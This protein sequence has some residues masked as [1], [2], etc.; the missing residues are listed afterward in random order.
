M[1][2][3]PDAYLVI[4]ALIFILISLYTEFVGASY[5]FVIA[6][7]FLGI[8]R[9]LTPSEILAGLANEQIAI[10]IMLLLVGEIYRQT[11]VLNGLFD[12]L[13]NGVKSPGQFRRRMMWITGSFSAFLNNTP[14]V[15]LMMP[16]VHTWSKRN[17]VSVSKFLIPLSYA[18]ILGGCVTLVGT[19]TN[20]IVGG[21][22]LDQ[23]V[24]P[25]VEPLG[26]FEF[27]AVGIPM[28]FIGFIYLSLASNKLLPDRKAA[29]E[30]LHDQDRKYIVEVEVKPGCPLIGKVIK[31]TEF[32]NA[33][34]LD[35]V[36]IVRADQRS[37]PASPNIV[38]FE[39]D[40]LVFAGNVQQIAE[41]V[42]TNNGLVIP[43]VGMFA[44]KAETQVVEIAISHNSSFI[45]KAIKY[46]NFRKQYDATII[47]IHRN[48]EVLSGKIE[49]VIIQSGDAILLLAG[50]NFMILE[51]SQKDF[52]LISQVKE[53]RKL[54]FLKT[55]I[56]I[57]GTIG[58]I[59]LSS[60]G[61]IKLF[62]GI[63]TLLLLSL[64]FKIS[65]PKELPKSIDYDLALII[66]LSLSLGIAMTKTGVAEFI[67]QQ[68][69][70]LF[71]P[72]GTLILLFGIYFINALLAAFI[73][74]KAA[75]ALIFP[76]VI[77]LA[78]DLNLSPHGMAL[79]VA[80]SAAAN[81]MTPIG[82][83]TNMMIYGPGGYKFKDYLK[84]GTPLTFIY[85]FVA[86]ITL[87]SIYF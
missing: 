12:K 63:I 68:F 25:N 58:I 5:S 82:Y 66:A 4:A 24:I 3:F 49:N 44:Q 43:S 35:I 75:V 31:E 71:L 72:H 74:N 11:G 18:T 51:R 80:Y 22:L 33:E 84:V 57:G 77:S 46:V 83:Q 36:E 48:G 47:A 42:N 60:L 87:Y 29:L 70:K 78:N 40:T 20:L 52:F 7:I 8:T 50:P 61:I 34:G 32:F 15:A 67:A 6:I 86:V 56:L 14:L 19:S 38:I 65:S 1:L 73:T 55:F 54:G 45:G 37:I 85:M 13:F 16:Y 21:L 23:K 2:V 28:A 53:I 59:V 79:L 30:K 41:M 76:I 26:I 69:I 39:N 27:V 10:I 64:M 81:F 9:V 17:Q 62:M